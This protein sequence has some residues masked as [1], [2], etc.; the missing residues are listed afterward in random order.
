MD[1]S[2]CH[3][4]DTGSVHH[5]K[6]DWKVEKTPSTYY[7]MTAYIYESMSKEGVL[8]YSEYGNLNGVHIW[9]S[10]TA[11]YDTLET[12]I[13]NAKSQ[14]IEVN[15]DYSTTLK[16][17]LH[18]IFL[19][20]DSGQTEPACQIRMTK[21]FNTANKAFQYITKIQDHILRRGHLTFMIYIGKTQKE[22]DITFDFLADC[23][24]KEAIVSDL[25]N[26]VS[27]QQ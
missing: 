2:I 14:Y 27:V 18:K 20:R 1:V 15:I 21:E 24:S 8:L 26:I 16:T 5:I 4:A 3:G 11:S 17:P 13:S 25:L 12:I 19:S 6:F 7:E 9:L 10:N 22:F 23:I